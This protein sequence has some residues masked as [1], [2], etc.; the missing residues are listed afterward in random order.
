MIPTPT[1]KAEMIPSRPGS[2]QALH[3]R[4]CAPLPTPD[5]KAKGQLGALRAWTAR[6]SGA[7][8]TI[9]PFND[10]T[11]RESVERHRAATL[12]ELLGTIAV[13]GVLSAAAIPAIRSYKPDPLVA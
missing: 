6:E 1:T 11:P 3:K 9:P 2:Q 5:S 10:S 12:L 13:I 4:R 8:L 7:D